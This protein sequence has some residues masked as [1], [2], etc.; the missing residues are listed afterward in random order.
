MRAV[1]VAT[2]VAMHK[3]G[4]VDAGLTACVLQ[5]APQGIM[6]ASVSRSLVQHGTRA[7]VFQ[8]ARA[9]LL[10]KRVPHAAAAVAVPWH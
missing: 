10:L 6:S 1:H 2:H 5:C 4:D 7:T 8:A 9:F 3:H